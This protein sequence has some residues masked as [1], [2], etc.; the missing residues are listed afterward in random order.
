MIEERFFKGLDACAQAV[1]DALGD[2]LVAAI[3]ARGQASLAVSGGRTP[4]VVFPQLA[5]REVAWDKVSVTLTDERWVP[6]DHVDSNEKLAREYLLQDKA[7]K[8]QFIG[9]KTPEATPEDGQKACEERLARVPLPLDAVYLGM[10]E[11]GHM[12]SLFPGSAALTESSGACAAT[13]APDGVLR[14]S[15]SPQTLL[16]ARHLILMLSGEKKRAVYERA[17]KP[18]PV[19]DLPLRLILHQDQVPIAIFIA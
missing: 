13:V 15:L 8:A 18:G 19:V 14:M 1:S 4:R 17:K 12:A 9:L 7:K 16:N 6:A 5:A 3:A 10:G 11:D 2:D